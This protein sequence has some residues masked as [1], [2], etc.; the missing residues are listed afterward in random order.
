MS[1]FIDTSPNY[2]IHVHVQGIIVSPERISYPFATVSMATNNSA[3]T[4]IVPRLKGNYIIA[5]AAASAETIY[6]IDMSVFSTHLTEST[7]LSRISSFTDTGN[8]EPN[9]NEAAAKN[10][11]Q[12]IISYFHTDD[13]DYYLV[14]VD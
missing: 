10:I 2:G 12:P 3:A 11:S 7:F 5:I 4:I 13:V 14:R 9:D 8:Y 1:D 6:A